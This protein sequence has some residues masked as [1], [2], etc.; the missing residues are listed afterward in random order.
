M[1]GILT[2]DR[3]KW[4]RGEIGEG[5]TG[6]LNRQGFMCCLGFDAPAC[7]LTPDQ[8]CDRSY[9]ADVERIRQRSIPNHWLTT[10]LNRLGQHP[11]VVR[12]AMDLNDSP[13]ISEAEREARLIPILKELGWD[14][15]RFV[16]GPE[17]V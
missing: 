6:L 11:Q 16:D 10:R 9:P 7:G 4:R 14:E 12:A 8:I 5:W 15:V 13:L 2:I 1:A 17:A 3:S